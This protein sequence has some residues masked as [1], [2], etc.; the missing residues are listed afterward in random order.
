MDRAGEAGMEQVKKLS[1][2]TPGYSRFWTGPNPPLLDPSTAVIVQENVSQA[3]LAPRYMMSSAIVTA[4]AAVI[5]DPLEV[6]RTRWQ[7]SGSHV[8]VSRQMGS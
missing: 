6:V 3:R 8:R 1:T 4:T 2:F 7:T 5:A